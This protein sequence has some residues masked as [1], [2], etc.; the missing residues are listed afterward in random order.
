MEASGPDPAGGVAAPATPASTQRVSAA[1]PSGARGPRRPASLIVVALVALVLLALL[2]LGWFDLSR[3]MSALRLDSAQRLRAAEEALLRAQAREAE[4]AADVRDAL[5][6]VA[7]LE[8]RLAESQSQQASLEALYREL[9]PSREELALTEVEQIV[10]L[11]AQQLALAGNVQAALAALQLADA[12]LG[13]L[14]RPRLLPLRRALARDMDT[15]KAVPFVDVAGVSLKLDQV[16]AQIDALPLARDERVEAPPRA[17]T[18]ADDPAWIR[19]LRDVWADLRAVVRI[20]NTD[21][22]APPLV[23][24]QEAFFLRENVRLRLLAARLA[25]LARDDAS[26][27]ADLDETLKWL[28]RYFETHAKPVQV[29]AAAITQARSIAMPADMPDLARTLE[30]VRTLR[31]TVSDAPDKPSASAGAA[32]RPR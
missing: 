10:T 14:D 3:D 20:E 23:T 11:A 32:A 2:G 25:L 21:R 30:S 4:L 22:A 17:S 26:Y 15:L 7:L 19:F 28:D 13:R 5:A 29:V 24:P 6:K 8:A 16:I 18:P 1:P 31:A 9:A 27:K 12:K